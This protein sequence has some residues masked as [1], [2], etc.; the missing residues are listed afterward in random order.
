MSEIG[1]AINVYAKIHSMFLGAGHGAA[2]PHHTQRRQ[3]AGTDGET[4][5]QGATGGAS[6]GVRQRGADSADEGAGLGSIHTTYLP[7]IAQQAPNRRNRWSEE[8]LGLAACTDARARARAR[9][10]SQEAR[11]RGL[12]RSRKFHIALFNFFVQFQLVCCKVAL[13]EGLGYFSGAAILGYMVC[14]S[15]EHDYARYVAGSG[16]R[17]SLIEISLLIHHMIPRQVPFLMISS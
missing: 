11:I 2:G 5:A 8:G 17:I 7:R 15:L 4:T 16:P 14:M 1:F 12:R 13:S 6:A 3:G 10:A 9:G